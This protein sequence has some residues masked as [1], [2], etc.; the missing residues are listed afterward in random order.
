MRQLRDNLG[1]REHLSVKGGQRIN[2]TDQDKVLQRRIVRDDN[3][4]A[5]VFLAGSGGHLHLSSE[6]LGRQVIDSAVALQDRVGF[7]AADSQQPLE[8]AVTDLAVAVKLHRKRLARVGIEVTLHRAAK[9]GLEVIGKI[10]RQLHG[11]KD[12][13]SAEGGRAVVGDV[14]G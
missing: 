4:A 9:K 11:G 5:S 13:T 8:L 1:R 2:A 12:T 10:H 7:V 3:H 6:F 14:M